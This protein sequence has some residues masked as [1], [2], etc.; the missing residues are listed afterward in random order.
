[1]LPS[2]QPQSGIPIQFGDDLLCACD[3]CPTYYHPNPRRPWALCFFDSNEACLNDVFAHYVIIGKARS[4]VV[5]LRFVSLRVHGVRVR[6][7]ERR[8][9]G[10]VST[11]RDSTLGRVVVTWAFGWREKGGEPDSRGPGFL[12]L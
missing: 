12:L 3:G 5:R 11:T 10:L 9:A 1:M 4:S 7:L 2:C 6:M 8:F